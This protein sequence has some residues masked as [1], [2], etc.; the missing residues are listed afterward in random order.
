[1]H[2]ISDESPTDCLFSPRYVYAPKV[3]KGLAEVWGLPELHQWW[4][5]DDDGCPEIIKEI[6]CL[7]EE[8]TTN[9][10]DHF[11]EDIRNMKSLFSKISLDEYGSQESSP[12]SVPVTEPSPAQ[13]SNA[14]Q[15]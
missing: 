11:R 7:T 5:P 4:V 8:R 15:Q 12:T 2:D 3:R 14:G 13:S 6:R 10:R 9:P 1:M